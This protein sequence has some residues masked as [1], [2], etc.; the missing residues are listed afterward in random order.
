[1]FV[2]HTME[3]SR[4]HHSLV[5]ANSVSEPEQRGQTVCS[6]TKMPQVLRLVVRG[7]T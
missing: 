3:R 1:M 7:G 2:S 4:K 5:D 6:G